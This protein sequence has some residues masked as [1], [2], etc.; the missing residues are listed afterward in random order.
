M[1]AIFLLPNVTRISNC[2]H[3]QP[4]NVMDD[5]KKRELE[6]THFLKTVCSV[7]VCHVSFRDAVF[8]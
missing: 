2:L 8:S 7:T 4:Y 3:Y 1:S 6:M 5:E